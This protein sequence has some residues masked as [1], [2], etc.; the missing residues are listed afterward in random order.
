MR[1]IVAF[2]KLFH[3]ITRVYLTLAIKTIVLGRFQ[4]ES[5]ANTFTENQEREE[6][7]LRQLLL[8]RLRAK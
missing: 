7:A 3:C 1:S 8:A 5:E 6:L 2:L 4:V